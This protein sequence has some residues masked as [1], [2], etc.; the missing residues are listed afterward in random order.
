ML[1][2][3]GGLLEGLSRPLLCF[4]RAGP[5]V[6]EVLLWTLV[7]PV[8]LTLEAWPCV[9]MPEVGG[10]TMAKARVLRSL[11]ERVPAIYIYIEM[12]I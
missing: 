11:K 12:Y 9:Y 6:Q 1:F 2:A 3:R 7:D 10:E 8:L 5:T 4:H